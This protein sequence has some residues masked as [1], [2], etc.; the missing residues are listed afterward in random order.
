MGNQAFIEG[1]TDAG[2]HSVGSPAVQEADA[3][4]GGIK[5]L[6]VNG[7]PEGARKMADVYPGS[8][9]S[10]LKAGSKTGIVT[11]T[12]VL[13]N[14]IY[15]VGSSKLSDDAAYAIVKTMWE[16]ND[17]LAAANPSLAAWTRERMV[18]EQAFIPYHPGAVKFFKEKGAWSANMDALQT[19]LLGQ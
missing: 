12:T 3:R 17:Q 9:P 7:A 6:S 1:R 14:D 15:L 18:S 16:H 19:E 13:T 11:D 8:Y 10:V 5:F 4:K 2:W